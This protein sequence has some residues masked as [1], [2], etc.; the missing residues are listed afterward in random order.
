MYAHVIIS[1]VVT[2]KKGGVTQYG[3]ILTFEDG[4]EVKMFNL[5]TGVRPHLVD[6]AD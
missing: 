5:E 6:Q 4:T 1:K 2:R 3:V